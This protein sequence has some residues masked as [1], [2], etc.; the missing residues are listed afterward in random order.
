MNS[1]SK[2]VTS[3]LI[4]TSFLLV[5]FIVFSSINGSKEFNEDGGITSKIAGRSTVGSLRADQVHSHVDS[6]A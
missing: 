3:L 1:K 5:F 2:I 4:L 6:N